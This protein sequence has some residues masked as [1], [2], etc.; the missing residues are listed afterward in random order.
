M[1]LVA[2][3]NSTEETPNKTKQIEEAKT[4]LDSNQKASHKHQGIDARAWM[5]QPETVRIGLNS[6]EIISNSPAKHKIDSNLA[7]LLLGSEIVMNS[8]EHSEQRT[9]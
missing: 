9:F 1:N 6:K 8:F 2:T 5:I 4:H 3:G 7:Q